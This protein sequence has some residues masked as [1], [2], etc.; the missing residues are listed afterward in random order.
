MDEPA[1]WA[2]RA[3]LVQWKTANAGPGGA[4]FSR[5]ARNLFVDRQA[6]PIPPDAPTI[7]P[8]TIAVRC[9]ILS[10]RLTI[11]GTRYDFRAEKRALEAELLIQAAPDDWVDGCAVLSQRLGDS[12][13]IESYLD[14]TTGRLLLVE[15]KPIGEGRTIEAIPR[16]W[17][18]A[19]V[20]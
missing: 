11:L 14:P 2:V 13:A 7:L 15:V 4:W 3:N 19:A 1:L 5:A 6:T 8:G 20:R 16:R 17:S 12:M 18:D 9:R 10:T